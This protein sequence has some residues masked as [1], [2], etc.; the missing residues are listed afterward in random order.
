MYFALI[1]IINKNY[2]QAKIDSIKCPTLYCG[3]DWHNHIKKIVESNKSCV[4]N[5]S[6]FIYENNDIC[7]DTAPPTTELI[8]DYTTYFPTEMP[9]ITTQV[10][11][12][13]NS[14]N[15]IDTNNFTEMSVISTQLESNSLTIDF[16][17]DHIDELTDFKLDTTND[18]SE[19]NYIMVETT[20]ILNSSL[21]LTIKEK[22]Q[23]KFEEIG[24]SI[25]PSFSGN[26]GEEVIIEGDDD[27]YF[28]LSA[29][30][31]K[32]FPEKSNN[33][34]NKFSVIDLGECEDRLREKYGINDSL[35]LIILKYEKISNASIEKTIQ[36]EVYEPINKTKLDLSICSDISID[37]YVPV[38]L[39]PKLQNLYNELH[40]SKNIFELFI[41]FYFFIFLL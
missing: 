39:S 28:C 1:H 26:N 5:C 20:N 27:F 35:S 31:G 25:L 9:T 34:S 3:D 10:S 16:K 6:N 19:S 15:D 8:Q 36:Y 23:L 17:T 38:E 29:Y 2:L 41:L 12:I 30:D 7:Y 18:I 13:N 4:D 40:Y 14:S 11:I 37:I 21:A 22:N 24:E 32:K 33:N